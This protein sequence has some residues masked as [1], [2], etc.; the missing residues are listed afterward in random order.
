MTLT[1]TQLR[2]H[3]DCL[4]RFPLA[5]LPTP[6]EHLKRFSKVL[7]GPQIHIK[8]DDCTGLAMGGNKTRH[9]EFLMAEALR[10]GAD[11]FVW[12][13]G[14]QSNNCRQT[15]A[16]CAKAG[17]DCQ[18]V[19]GRGRP[20]DGPD[21]VQGN[22]LLDH[23]MGGAYEIVEAIIGEELDRK[24]AEKAEQFRARGRKVYLW[25]RDAVKPLAAVS[26][27]LC[28]IEILEQSA[29]SGFVPDAIYVSS[30]GSTGSGLALG[31]AVLGQ[32]FPVRNICPIRWEWDTQSDMAE[33]ANS[34]AKLLGLETRLERG[35][36]ELTFDFIPPGYGKISSGGLEATALV[37]R[38]EGILLDPIYTAKAMAG[39][40]SDIR[41]GRLADAK[42]VV[43]VHTGGTPALFAY[44]EELATGIAPRTLD[45]N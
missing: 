7:G 33:I 23:L 6:F 42:N 16:A 44:N 39:L 40:V 38:T 45:V 9:N 3:V 21:P 43:F 26:Y 36:I 8:R 34:A 20:A 35:D 15:V 19:L 5:H 4:P 17:L 31:A 13:A 10:Q 28:L 29:A 2:E 41:K 22:L 32:K 24:I 18:L 37:A 27:V 25:D 14:V 12:G 30:A 1:P 11:T